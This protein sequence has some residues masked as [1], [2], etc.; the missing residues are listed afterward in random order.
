[1]TYKATQHTQALISFLADWQVRKQ[2]EG[3]VPTVQLLIDE[4]KEKVLDL[5]KMF[6]PRCEYCE[7]TGERTVQD[8]PDDFQRVECDCYQDLEEHKPQ[9]SE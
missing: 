6:D 3:L 5:P 9:L 1:M 2:K 8:G 4:L 7:G